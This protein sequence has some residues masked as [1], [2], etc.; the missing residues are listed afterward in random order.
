MERHVLPRVESALVLA[1]DGADVALGAP[2]QDDFFALLR[3]WAESFHEPWPRLRLLLSV[4]T[5][6]ALLV[7]D[8]NRSPFN[9]TAP[10]ILG[11]LR[12]AQVENLSR[13]HNLTWSSAQIGRLM[14]LVGGHPYLVRLLMHRAALHGTPLDELLD[15]GLGSRWILFEDL[16]RIRAWLSRCGLL[17]VAV[18]VARDPE[19]K[20][21]P[22]EYHRVIRAGVLLEDT[23]SSRRLRN[24]LYHL[25]ATGGP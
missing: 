3:A 19:A 25:A 13:R 9:L 21:A 12:L 8:P 6:P 4:S 2:Y 11:D 15:S 24:R 5:T 18:R 22:D 23:P 1:I 7:T 16:R 17:D 10:I 20:L 14:D